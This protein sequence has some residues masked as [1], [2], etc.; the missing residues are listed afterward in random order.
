MQ[1]SDDFKAHEVSFG[2]K[3]NFSSLPNLGS[4]FFLN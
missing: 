4:F 3:V 1:C 2:E